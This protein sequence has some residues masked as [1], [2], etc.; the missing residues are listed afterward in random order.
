MSKNGWGYYSVPEG[1]HRSSR[2]FESQRWPKTQKAAMGEDTTTFLPLLIWFGSLIMREKIMRKDITC[3][4]HKYHSSSW[5]SISFTRCASFD[6][7]SVRRTSQ[8]PNKHVFRKTCLVYTPKQVDNFLVHEKI[9]HFLVPSKLSKTSWGQGNNSTIVITC[10]KI[11]FGPFQ[12]TNVIFKCKFSFR[13]ILWVIL[14]QMFIA[15]LQPHFP[16]CEHNF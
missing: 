15:Y 4:P 9:N 6:M 1:S 11:L 16:V 14:F 12:I 7:N 5:K 8:S 3:S 13:T 2:K 10:S